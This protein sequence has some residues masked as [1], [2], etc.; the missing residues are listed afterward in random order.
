MAISAVPELTEISKILSPVRA[1]PMQL[2]TFALCPPSVVTK[3][4]MK[5]DVQDSV[6]PMS[7]LRWSKC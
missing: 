3:M 1:R 5:V 7:D 2:C 4:Q 6:M